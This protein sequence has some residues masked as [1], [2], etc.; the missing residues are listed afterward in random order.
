MR[1]ANVRLTKPPSQVG[2]ANLR[3]SGPV[4]LEAAFKEYRQQHAANKGN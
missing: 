4:R 1:C 3:S 2:K